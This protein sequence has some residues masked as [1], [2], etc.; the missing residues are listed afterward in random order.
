MNL[1]KY[2]SELENK[3]VQFLYK[4]TERQ[5]VWRKGFVNLSYSNV[6]YEYGLALQQQEK[7][8]L[9]KFV[10]YTGE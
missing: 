9:A 2:Q 6:A 5:R 1:I 7:F 10:E 3:K 4:E 8:A